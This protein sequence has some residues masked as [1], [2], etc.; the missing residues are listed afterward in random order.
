M[1]WIKGEELMQEQSKR[2]TKAEKR[3]LQRNNKLEEIF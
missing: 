2:W 3:K 1:I